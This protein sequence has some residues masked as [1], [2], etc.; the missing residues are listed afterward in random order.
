MQ[1]D[2]KKVLYLED[3]PH[4][5]EIAIMALEEFSDLTVL[6][7]DHGQDAIARFE[8]FQPDLLLFDVMLPDIDGIQT[9]QEIRSRYDA[10]PPVIFMTAKAQVQEQKQYFDLGAISVIVKPFD[11]VHLGDQLK[12]LWAARVNGRSE[13]V[14]TT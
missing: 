3:D 2:L 8:D 14:E 4:I 5:S 12:S 9:L 10:D 13:P 11:A 1:K 6:H 7:C